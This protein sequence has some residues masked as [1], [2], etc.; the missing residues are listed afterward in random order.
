[1]GWFV[2]GLIVGAIALG[3]GAVTVQHFFASHKELEPRAA[4]MGVLFMGV[5]TL[6]LAG[7][8]TWFLLNSP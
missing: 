7:V 6:L 1:M 2:Y 5:P 3:L 4:W 8:A